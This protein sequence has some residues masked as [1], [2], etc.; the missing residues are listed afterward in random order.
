MVLARPLMP[1]LVLCTVLYTRSVA[2]CLALGLL[3]ALVP[4]LFRF[5]KVSAGIGG[6]LVAIE[7][8]R[9]EGLTAKREVNDT[10]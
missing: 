5:I 1:A 8:G 2:A 3:L 7:A 9:G 6:G 10:C 4:C